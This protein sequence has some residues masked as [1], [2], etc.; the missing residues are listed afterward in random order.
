[1]AIAILVALLASTTLVPAMMGIFG[2]RQFW[3][4]RWR[5][6]AP[7]QQA[8]SESSPG[9]RP[10]PG[11][12]FDRKK[13][14]GFWPRLARL[15][16]LRPGLVLVVTLGALAPPVLRS[17]GL[18]W[19]YDTLTG[20]KESFPQGIGN[21]SAGVEIAKR[22]W[23]V[24]EIAPLSLLVRSA[25]PAS[26]DQWQAASAQ[27]A[28]AVGGMPGVRDVR[29]LTQPLGRFVPLPEGWQGIPP[30]RQMA[31]AEYAS[32]DRAIRLS[33]VLDHPPFSL[34]AMSVAQNVQRT[35]IEALAQTGMEAEVMMAGA[36][37]EMMDVRKV[38][39]RDFYLIAPLALGAIFLIV[40]IL[41]RDAL[42]TAFMVICTVLGYM[43]TLGLT[44]WVFQAIGTGGLDWK[45]EVLLFIVMVAVGV[46]YSIFL[47][48]R[49]KQE[50]S[51]WPM[52][53][54]TRRAVIHT[55]PVISS[56]GVIMAATLGSLMAGDLKLLLQLGFAFSL[57]MLLDT[58]MVRPLLLPA[59]AVL[60][61]PRRKAAQE[62][63]RAP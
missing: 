17:V 47:A 36:T 62:D 56:C 58:F 22:H 18:T 55:G 48:A 38:T 23:P 34:E 57:G 40:L 15:V 44:H 7:V 28:S 4:S 32:G 6:K 59:F 10:E 2:P 54:A 25:R 9:P 42:L 19:V 60:V 35:A 3:P 45:V 21:A 41:L 5:P 63:A 16:A 26:A 37:A 31:R 1:V 12:L 46:D 39:Q 51:R 20:I 50:A 30:A 43:A 53:E 24:G 29:G 33:V 49:I 52:V 13:P 11:G 27:I 61:R 8:A 14:R